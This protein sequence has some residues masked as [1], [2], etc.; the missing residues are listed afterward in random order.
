MINPLAAIEGYAMLLQDE[1]LNSAE[2]YEYSQIIIAASQQLSL[3]TGNILQL[4]KLEN[5]EIVLEKALFRLDEQI[6]QA[7]L[8]LES[9]WSEKNIIFHL[10]LPSICYHGNQ[11][12]LMQVWINLIENAIKFSHVN[13]SIQVTLIENEKKVSVLIKDT[14]IG[15]NNETKQRLYDKFYQADKTRKMTGNG[16]G[17][18]L[19]K[20][21]I[22]LSQG[23]ILVESTE[24]NGTCFTVSL[25]LDTVSE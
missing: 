19:V 3:L 7:I 2:R 14:G 8:F 20:R 12:L 24:N 4:S 25:P 1:Q 9:K 11:E 16:L 10:N 21:I 23:S 22:Q 17:L 13:S 5:S 6:R 15:M 18:T